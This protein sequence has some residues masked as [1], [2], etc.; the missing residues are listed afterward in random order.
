[1]LETCCHLIFRNSNQNFF[2]IPGST[3]HGLT[4]LNQPAF[5][6]SMKLSSFVLGQYLDE[7]MLGNTSYSKQ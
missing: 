6:R 4:T 1:M 2:K 3:F 7:C 5:V